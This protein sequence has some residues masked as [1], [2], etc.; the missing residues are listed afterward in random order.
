L[1]QEDLEFEASQGSTV[2]YGLKK[3]KGREGKERER[4]DGRCGRA[5]GEALCSIPETEGEREREHTVVNSVSV[6]GHSQ[7]FGEEGV[8]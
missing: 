2:K 6:E 5:L 4:G 8:W 3:R 7:G 1:R